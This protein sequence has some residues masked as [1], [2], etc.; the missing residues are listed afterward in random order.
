L[1]EALDSVLSQDYPALELIVVDDG[2][3]DDTRAICESYGERI[4]YQW[5]KNS[6]TCSVPRNHGFELAT[7]S[8]VVFFDADDLMSEGRLRKQAEFMRKFPDAV[9]VFSD[10]RNFDSKGP[11]AHTHFSTCVEMSRALR[12]QEPSV[13]DMAVDGALFRRLLIRENFTITGAALYRTEA[14]RALGGF[15]ES[16]RA[17]EDFD[18][19]YRMARRGPCGLLREVGFMR[20]LHDKNMSWDSPRIIEFKIRSRTKLLESETSPE[21]QRLLRNALSQLYRDAALTRARTGN[22][23]WGSDLASSISMQPT[24]VVDAAATFLR[25]VKYSLR[26]R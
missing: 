5:Q 1:R 2:S 6:G 24:Q 4:R 19:N 25:C 20:R 16:L 18:M 3:V 22:R 7:G 21:L 10:Y 26:A 11:A 14:Y 12:L 13:T 15:D 9:A 23:Q 17:S 8:L